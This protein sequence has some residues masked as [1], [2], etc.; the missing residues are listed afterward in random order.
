MMKFACKDLG[1]DC[2]FETTGANKEE[3]M[4]QAMEHGNSVHAT[5]MQSMT[6]EQ[7]AQFGKQLDASI[8]YV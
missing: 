8:K 1:L 4:R 5:E 2:N 3:T 7:L 6:K